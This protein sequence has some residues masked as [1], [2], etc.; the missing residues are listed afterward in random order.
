M[1]FTDRNAL[2]WGLLTAAVGTALSFATNLASNLVTV[3]SWPAQVAVWLTVFALIGTVALLGAK[4]LTPRRPSLDEAVEHLRNAVE[5]RWEDDPSWRSV[6]EAGRLPIRWRLEHSLWF[7]ANGSVEAGAD[8]GNSASA[9]APGKALAQFWTPRKPGSKLVVLG[10]GGS[11]KTELLVGVLRHLLTTWQKGDP[12]PVLVPLAS[13]DPRQRLRPWLADWM[14]ANFRILGRRSSENP[15]RNLAEAL[16]AGGRL[17]LILDG[18]DEIAPESRPDALRQSNDLGGHTRVLLSSRPAEYRSAVGARNAASA[19]Q[20]VPERS[21]VNPITGAKGIFLLP[22]DLSEVTDYLARRSE[23][24]MLWRRIVAESP[25][26]ARTIRTP[27]MVMLVD[28]IYSHDSHPRS[29]PPPN[30][31]ELQ[32]CRT[33]AELEESLL[34]G[35]LPARYPAPA[36]EAGKCRGPVWTATDAAHWLGNLARTIGD[37]ADLRWW[38]LDGRAPTVWSRPA[39]ADAITMVVVLV[40]TAL[41]AGSFNGWLFFSARVAVTDAVRISAATLVCYVAMRYLTTSYGAAV[42]GALGAYVAG[43]LSGSYDLSISIGLVAA[44]SWRPLRLK[45]SGLRPAIFVAILVVL[46]SMAIRGMNLLLPALFAPELTQGFAAGALDGFVN[47]WDEDVN[48]WLAA[49]M[50]TGIVTWAAMTV[51]GNQTPSERRASHRRPA[52]SKPLVPALVVGGLVASID[53]WADGFRDDVTHAWMIGPADGLAA[54]FAVWYVAFWARQAPWR[55]P[56]ATGEAA[57]SARLRR[58]PE[59]TTR[60]V[61]AGTLLA[62]AGAAVNFLGHRARTDIS[63]D[64]A[65]AAAE[66]LCLGVLLWIAL[67]YRRRPARPS[68]AYQG[69]QRPPLVV[70][71][72]IVAPAAGI[73]L[74]VTVLHGLSS[75]ASRG[76]VTGLGIGSVVLFALHR[77]YGADGEV[78]GPG[79]DAHEYGGRWPVR[80]AE[81]GVFMTAVVGILAGFGYGLMFGLVA[82]LASRVSRAIWRRGQP[83]R[84]I[85]PS[86]AGVVGGAGLGSLTVLASAFNGMAPRWLAVIGFTS[87]IA[88]ALTFGIRMESGPENLVTSP[89][90]LFLRDRRAFFAI[91]IVVAVA[92][93]VSLGSRVLAGGRPWDAGALAAL[94]TMLT[95]GMTA[96][97]AIATAATRFGT[98]AVTM[99]LFA[100]RGDLPWRLMLFLNDA[101]MN[102]GVLRSNGETYQFRHERLRQQIARETSHA[103]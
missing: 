50:V 99:A 101:H 25:A 77:R 81:A 15:E 59:R 47:R 95:F 24:P 45:R 56:R 71:P 19:D 35:F 96:G 94:S 23:D 31:K 27:L 92:L 66:G 68:R 54:G 36:G 65:R 32:R 93:A 88:L 80:P 102:R 79:S 13:W 44:F 51:T 29:G 28:S 11:G 6:Q 60:P 78:P 74:V 22:Q 67:A 7:E 103:P 33:Q 91:T 62:A 3:S 98:F 8:G 52:L 10:S 61:L 4:S 39:V 21:L 82:V 9:Q 55:G 17:A 97:L 49:G 40:W 2:G 75:G 16:I 86:W 73:A 84:G 76:I 46:V 89:R 34:A 12:A 70:W 14:R 87:G 18:F 72:R 53:S 57:A 20:P 38:E 41:S 58:L 37:R 43:T 30:L 42:L 26:L 83:T 63:L 69:R 1:T 5:L 64:W 100:S 90:T 48:G 85:V